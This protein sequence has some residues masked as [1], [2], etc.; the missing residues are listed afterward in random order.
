[1][2]TT[3]KKRLDFIP[4]IAI[5]IS[6]ALLLYARVAGEILFQ[7]RHIVGLLLLIMPAIM[8][9]YSHKLGVLSTGLLLLLGLFGAI[10][11]NPAISTM[12]MGTTINDGSRITFLYF[13]PIFLVWLILHL[14][15]S[16]RYYTGVITKKYWQNIKSDE[17]FKIGIQ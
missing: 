11:Y 1:M 15:I 17:P 4:Y 3:I 16:G 2:T 8:F 5:I 13:Q 9:Y 14:F 10:S 6:A 7:G 12:T